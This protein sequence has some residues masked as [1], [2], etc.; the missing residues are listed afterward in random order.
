[1]TTCVYRIRNIKNNDSYYGSA[2][3]VKAR[4]S[5]H[6]SLLLRNKHH[7][8]HLQN[9]WNK[10]GKE[11]FV[12]EIIEEILDKS[13]LIEREQW[14]LDNSSCKYNIC[15]IA[16]SQLGTRRTDEQRKRMSISKIGFQAGSKHPMYGKR[17]ELSPLFGRK[18]HNETKRK[19]GLANKGN[20]ANLGK[21]FSEEH[22]KK[23]GASNKISLIGNKNASKKENAS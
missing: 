13:K 6:K 16:G 23:I 15:D 9:A 4:F 8:I 20:K 7:C 2:V 18:C 5:A 12:F 3:D 21:K 22:R 19:I 14:Y 11:N 1:M 10:Y 17:G